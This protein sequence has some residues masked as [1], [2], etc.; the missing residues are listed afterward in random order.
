MFP[1]APPQP[2][3]MSLETL[4][5][6]IGI[7]LGLVTIG[8]LVFRVGQEKQSRVELQ[9]SFRRHV[10]GVKQRHDD[11]ERAH[12][13]EIDDLKRDFRSVSEELKL[14]VKQTERDLRDEEIMPLKQILEEQ[15]K[16]SEAFRTIAASFEIRYSELSKE[17]DRKAPVEVIDAL[18]AQMTRMEETAIMT[19]SHVEK[20]RLDLAGTLKKRPTR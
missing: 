11:Q 4:A 13:K 19:A 18:R 12:V 8:G 10:A 20:I 16:H 1:F 17:L 2:T 6:I 9:K 14:A 3:G 5:A 7:V 15:R